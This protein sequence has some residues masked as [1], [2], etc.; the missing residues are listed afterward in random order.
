MLSLILMA[1]DARFKYIAGV[2]QVLSA[3][4]YPLQKLANIP[5]SIYDN[6]GEFFA[7]HDL[8]GENADLRQQKLFDQEQLQRWQALEAENAQLRKLLD[9]AQRVEGK[10]VMA[11][12][13]H[14]PRDPFNRKIMLDKGSQSGMQPGQVV[15]DDAGV[16]GQVTRSYPWVSEVTLI[17]DKDH[18]VPVQVVRN[19]LRSVVSGSGKDATLEL[20]YMAGN[21]DLQEGDL[22]VTSGIDGV[23]PPGLPVAV[24][25][26]IERN[27]T[28]VF[29]RVTC[30]PVA[31]V[32]NNRQLLILSML[33]PAPEIPAEAIEMKPNNKKRER[34]G[35]R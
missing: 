5:V 35:V 10:A 33:P 12:I 6:V 29:A 24:V 11:E 15:V 30:I 8:A 16:V 1:I 17:T 7:T 20:R 32:A 9:A 31:G 13:L 14:I 23:Y 3:V 22:L 18:S 25:S 26:K 27:P 21:T 34:V 28:Y 2:R 19:G 4:I